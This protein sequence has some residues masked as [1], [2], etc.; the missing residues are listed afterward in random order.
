MLSMRL[1]DRMRLNM[2]LN[3]GKTAPLAAIRSA[4][5]PHIFPATEKKPSSHL[6][7]PLGDKTPFPN[8]EIAAVF[9][10]NKL[11]KLVLE[12]SSLTQR[13]PDSS[14]FA[15][16][17]LSTA[18]PY[19][20]TAHAHAFQ[21]PATN[22]RPWDV[23]PLAPSP[24]PLPPAHGWAPPMEW[25]MPNYGAVGQ[26]L[27]ARAEG[28]A[29][30]DEKVVGIGIKLGDPE[31]ISW[32]EIPVLMLP[33]LDPYA[34]DPFGC[35]SVAP[36]TKS[37]ARTR[38]LLASHSG[39]RYC[40]DDWEPSADGDCDA[41]TRSTSNNASRTA[42]TTRTYIRKRVCHHFATG[43]NDSDVPRRH[44]APRGTRGGVEGGSNDAVDR[45][46]DDG[47]DATSTGRTTTTTASLSLGMRTQPVSASTAPETTRPRD[48][49]RRRARD[50]MI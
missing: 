48:H 11:P 41:P 8:R 22:D 5:A 42:R 2:R 10:G 30:D 4:N 23:S 17:S 38:R 47:D 20:D 29:E 45:S 37:A 44:D 14:S 19:P 36:S 7:R 34:D 26:A 32:E 35:V 27:R 25:G 1:D 18:Y 31:T 49:P 40:T 9:G 50:R 16:P 13:A 6:K 39:T 3:M 24:I 12:N 43:G 28:W 33:E 15:A 21:T 46:N